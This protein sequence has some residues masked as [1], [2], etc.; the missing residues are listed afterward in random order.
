MNW[1]RYG[2]RQSWLNVN[3]HPTFFRKPRGNPK[4]DL[5]LDNWCPARDTN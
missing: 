5:I 3:Y 1:K 2:K 4:K